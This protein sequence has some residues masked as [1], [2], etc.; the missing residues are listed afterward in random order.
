MQPLNTAAPV[1]NS[2]TTKKATPSPGERRHFQERNDLVRRVCTASEVR[3]RR[4]AGVDPMHI[5]WV[6]RHK[7]TY[8]QHAKVNAAAL[9]YYIQ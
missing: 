3:R 9:A 7:L 8:C 1:Q 4:E 5:L 2:N 6:E